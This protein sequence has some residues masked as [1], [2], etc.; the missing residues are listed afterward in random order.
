[1]QGLPWETGSKPA[2]GD[3]NGLDEF[4]TTEDTTPIN[5]AQEP[6]SEDWLH[7]L[8]AFLTPVQ[9]TGSVLSEHLFRM[10]RRRSFKSTHLENSVPK[11]KK[12][13]VRKI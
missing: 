3:N 2:R 4:Y 12:I 9:W 7:Y 5:N 1:M 13:D 8:W 10:I 11:F 6:K